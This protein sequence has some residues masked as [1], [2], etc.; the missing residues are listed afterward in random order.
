MKLILNC[1]LCMRS[2]FSEI[3]IFSGLSYITVVMRSSENLSTWFCYF[4]P[5]QLL[6][7]WVQFLLHQSIVPVSIDNYPGYVHS[8]NDT[9]Y[10]TDDYYRDVDAQKQENQRQK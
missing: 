2:V 10:T 5:L 4:I 7:N 9:W 6:V 8:N 3:S 1:T